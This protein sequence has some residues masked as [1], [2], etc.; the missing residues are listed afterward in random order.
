MVDRELLQKKKMFQKAKNLLSDIEGIEV[1]AYEE[2]NVL[3]RDG[4]QSIGF[5]DSAKLPDSKIWYLSEEHKIVDWIIELLNFEDR[6]IYYLW[7]N[8]YLIKIQFADARKA[9]KDL[10]NKI[11][12]NFK[13]FILISCDK[14]IM[15]EFG[16]DSR[17]EYH[18]LYDRYSLNIYKE[19][20]DCVH[21]HNFADTHMTI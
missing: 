7:L 10:W 16:N 6:D 1:L 19:I 3:N 11:N 4:L 2:Q 17:D 15:H 8:D 21:K 5:F 14:K 12:P 20:P 9:V 18:I 13:G